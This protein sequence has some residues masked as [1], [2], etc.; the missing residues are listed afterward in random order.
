[1]LSKRGTPIATELPRQ[2]ARWAVAM[3]LCLVASIRG[4]H[5]QTRH[6]LLALKA[7]EPSR[8]ARAI[9]TEATY[10]SMSSGNTKRARS[11][12]S[13]ARRHAELLG[14]PLALGHADASEGISAFLTGRW[15][16]G[17]ELSE[18][19]ELTFRQRS[20]AVAW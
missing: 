19:A 17:R 1:M 4:A 12:T 9:A 10:A 5:F 11:L 8:I 2:V 18:K 14:T 3:G 7:G 16:V 6:M 20:P 13:V 15:S